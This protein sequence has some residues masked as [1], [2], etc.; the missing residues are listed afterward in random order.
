MG[1]ASEPVLL[2]VAR[3]VE[4]LANNAKCSALY[5]SFQWCINGNF[6]DSGIQLIEDVGTSMTKDFCQ[7]CKLFGSVR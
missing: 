1:F 2:S 6:V 4:E 3:K 5:A 7:E